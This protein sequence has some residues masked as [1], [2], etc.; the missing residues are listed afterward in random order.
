MPM[1]HMAVRARG[2][3]AALSHTL[4][5]LQNLLPVNLR[6]PRYIQFGHVVLIGYGPCC[7]VG[8]DLLLPVRRVYQGPDGYHDLLGA[9]LFPDV[10]IA[11]CGRIFKI[12]PD[13][14]QFNR[15]DNYSSTPP[16]IS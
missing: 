9:H 4:N 5:R 12:F 15:G 16:A 13:I 14:A 11:K 2:M 10:V 6:R 3:G 8:K 7:F 1:S